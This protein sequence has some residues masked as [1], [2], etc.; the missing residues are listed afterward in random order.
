[1]VT[2]LAAACTMGPPPGAPPAHELAVSLSRGGCEYCASYTLS[3]YR[4]GKL[5]YHGESRVPLLGDVTIDVTPDQLAELDLLFEGAPYF[6]LADAYTTASAPDTREAAICNASYSR[7]C[8]PP[9]R[10]TVTTRYRSK[11]RDKRVDHYLGDNSAPVV[12]F[13]FENGIDRIVH[14]ERFVGRHES[15]E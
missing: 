1:V 4:D 10:G 9:D 8:T 6:D 12:L 3:V 15:F 2:V 13:T 14:S 7:P 5:D 11:G